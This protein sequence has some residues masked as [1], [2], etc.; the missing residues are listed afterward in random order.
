MK[1]KLTFEEHAAMGQTL[2]SL[3]RQLM[4]CYTTL[5]NAYPQSGPE[6][7]PGKKLMQ[8]AEAVDVARDAL[9]KAVFRE[10]PDDAETSTYYP[11]L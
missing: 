10:H 8:A 6:A 11:H 4:Q 3:R 1:P 7:V 2:A 5:A 9:E